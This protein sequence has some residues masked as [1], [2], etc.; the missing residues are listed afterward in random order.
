MIEFFIRDKFE[1]QRW[2]KIRQSKKKKYAVIISVTMFLIMVFSAFNL[3]AT[4][5]N[6]IKTIDLTIG[7]LAMPTSNQELEFWD[8]AS[9]EELLK[10]QERKKSEEGFN[11]SLD[12]EL[13]HESVEKV[14]RDVMQKS[15][16]SFIMSGVLVL[17]SFSIFIAFQIWYRKKVNSQVGDAEETYQGEFQSML[18]TMRSI[19]HDFLNHIQVIQ[20][21]MKI[22]REDRAYEYVNSLTTEVETMELPVVIKNPA[23]FILLQSKWAR[24]QNEKVDMHLHVDDHL[25][26]HIHTIDLIKIFS[27]LIDNAFDATLL[28][29]ESER[30]IN[31]EA[32]VTQNKYIFRVENIGPTISKENLNKIFQ[33]GYS[34]KAEKRGVPRGDGLS[35]VKQ[36]VLK[37]GGTINVESN[38]YSTLFEV[39]IPYKP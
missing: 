27:N 6:T 37:Y 28:G 13:T 34:T 22:G 14:K 35:I 17:L 21:L 1:G 39:K 33:A 8:T 3:Y 26:K 11:G 9:L 23:L 20:G 29:L 16:P 30:F 31:I 38:K 18:H 15:I 2:L 25:F 10:I 24:A 5:L 19:R 4:Y 12:V 7:H 36:V 32:R